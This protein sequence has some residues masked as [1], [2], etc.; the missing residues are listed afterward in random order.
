MLRRIYLIS[1]LGIGMFGMFLAVEMK[2]AVAGDG[3]PP[4]GFFP[5]MATRLCFFTVRRQA[6]SSSLSKAGKRPTCAEAPYDDG[7]WALLRGTHSGTGG[8]IMR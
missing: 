8:K 6:S 4:F 1:D 5:T 2:L 3:R 7:L